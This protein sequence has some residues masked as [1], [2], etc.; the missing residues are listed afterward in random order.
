MAEGAFQAHD[1]RVQASTL[2]PLPAPGKRFGRLSFAV[3]DTEPT[4]PIITLESV[5][6][7]SQTAEA[8]Q[9]PRMLPRLA[10]TNDVFAN[11]VCTLK[12][13]GPDGST[14]GQWAGPVGQ[15]V[16]TDLPK[17]FYRFDL[18]LVDCFGRTLAL[19]DGAAVGQTRPGEAAEWVDAVLRDTDRPELADYKGWLQYLAFQA[20]QSLRGG[21]PAGGSFWLSAVELTDWARKAKQDPGL[22]AKLRGRFEWAYVSKV[23]GSS[24]PFAIVVPEKYDP[25]RPWPLYV[26]LHGAGGTDVDYGGFAGQGAADRN[27]EAIEMAVVGRSRYGG[28]RDLGEVDVLEAMD[29]VRAHWH[30]DPDRIHLAGES[31]G[32]GGTWQIASR[33]PDLFATARPLCSFG[34]GDPVENLLYVPVYCVHSV[35]DWTVPVS[36]SRAPLNLLASSGGLAVRSETSGIGHNVN[37][38]K[39]GVRA[40]VNWTLA[41]RRPS[42]VA[43]VRFTATDELS[44]GAYWVEVAQWGPDNRPARFD[45]RLDNANWLLAETDNVATLRLDLAHSPANRA[46]DDRGNEPNRDW[47]PAG[48]ATGG[49]L[50]DPR[51][52]DLARDRRRAARPERP[53]ARARRRACAVSRRADD[54]RLRH[55]RGRAGARPWR[56]SLRPS[57]EA[58]RSGGRTRVPMTAESEF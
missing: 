33:H 2:I 46:A 5:T 39:E 14:K 51:W 54:D 7:T 55:R 48:P 21:S 17:G 23:D 25:A 4:N 31:M 16:V 49:G 20:R 1:G 9:P 15:A 47:H 52:P 26:Y 8:G 58:L 35:D 34:V 45:V 18:E 42:R 40:S 12:A 10:S 24:Q 19:S 22:L 50:A 36:L 27:D 32:G 30:I 56:T 41:H 28:Y 37:Q 29:F 6:M 43:R 38:W 53:A 57:N 3:G 11:L 13:F 44:R